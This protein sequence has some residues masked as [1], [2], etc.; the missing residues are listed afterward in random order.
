MTALSGRPTNE[1]IL[2]KF[3][4]T[5]SVTAIL[6]TALLTAARGNVVFNTLVSFTYTNGPTYGSFGVASRSGA[7]VQAN[8]GNFYGA[9]PNGGVTE[10]SPGYFGTIYKMAPDGTFSSLYLFGTVFAPNGGN[11]NGHW[12]QGTLLQ[13]ADGNLYGTTQYGS[14][15]PNLGAANAGTVFQITT[16]GDFTVLYNFGNNAGFKLGWGFTNYDGDGPVSGIIQGS[17][18]NFYGTT[19][20]YGAYGNGTIFQ[21]TPGGALTTLHAFTALDPDNFYENVDGANPMA[22]LIE[23]K[24][25]NFYGTTT[26]GGTIAYGSG[27]VFKISPTGEFI[28]LHSFPNG[29]GYS[30]GALVQGHDGTLYGTTSG[31]FGTVFEITTNGDFTTLHTFN[32]SDG[33]APKAGLVLGSDGNLYGTAEG[34][35]SDGWFGTMFQITTNG[36]LTTLHTFNGTDGSHPNAALVQATDGSFYGTTSHGAAGYGTIFQMIIPPAFQNIVE[37]NGMI[38][39]TCSFMPGQKYQLQYNND[40]SSTNWLNAGSSVIASNTVVAV[41]GPATNSQCFYRI[42]L[43][44]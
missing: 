16:N 8:D 27:T 1:S 3:L 19:A 43:V 12:P 17:D 30:L 20:A 23:G 41:S 28:T 24:D 10:P 9:T 22:E 26:Q 29:N 14:T 6:S 18:G 42:A 7:M 35:G 33:S 11:D 40:L 4:K 36:V 21:L 15:G 2:M 32:G 37:T 25:G 38:N 44:P 31:S 5:L 34:G 13:A 39:A